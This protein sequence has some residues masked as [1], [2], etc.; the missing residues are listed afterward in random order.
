MRYPLLTA[1]MLAT[2]AVAADVGSRVSG[3]AA[4]VNERSVRAHM[5]FL[6]GDALNGRG[7]G[8]RDEWIAAQYLASRMRAAGLTPLGDEGGFVQTVNLSRT[9]VEGT[10]E[11]RAGNERLQHGTQMLVLGL[12]AAAAAGPLQK[13]KPGTAAAGGS[14]LLMPAG[15]DPENAA[16]L[17]AAAVVLWR[18]NAQLRS[19]WSSLA[20]RPLNVGGARLA[21][22]DTA[23]PATPSPVQIL[24]SA[25]A[26]DQ[27]AAMPAG[28]PVQFSARTQEATSR[29]WN[30][31]G[32]LPGTDAVRGKQVILLTAHLDHLGA[33]AEGADRIYNGADDDASGSIAVLSLAEAL[34]RQPRP[35]RS[36][37][38]AFFG[39]EEVGSIG[40]RHFLARHTVPVD[41]II[42]NLEF[43]MIGRSDPAV[44]DH[45]LWLTGWERT[46]LGPALSA[47]GARLVGDP[48]PKE[49]F[50]M[51]SDNITLARRGVIA[52]TVS[53]FGLHAQYHQPDDDIAHIDFRHMTDSIQSMLGPVRWLADSTF[54]PAWLPGGQ[55]PPK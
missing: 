23:A 18:E 38:F 24:L 8:T 7:S 21:G 43:E 26:Y 29:T 22:I 1:S 17:D 34:A 4:T 11:L 52:Q 35:K 30:A 46:N 49:K 13:F 25:A 27:L 44:A 47:H 45:T 2:G 12:D 3:G 5:E 32:S 33:A 9:Q 28:T 50:F 36:I 51:R 19:L 40:A 10:P 41:A 14:V 31:V 53:S 16:G 6:A 15:A 55:P 54:R 48:H 42:A 20:G 39:S 37:V